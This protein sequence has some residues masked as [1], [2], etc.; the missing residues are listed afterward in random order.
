MDAQSLL[1]GFVC[2]AIVVLAIEEYRMSALEKRIRE[3]IWKEIIPRNFR[4]RKKL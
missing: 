2:G 3:T 4:N 1:L